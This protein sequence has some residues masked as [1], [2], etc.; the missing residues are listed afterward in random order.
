MKKSIYV[1]AVIVIAVLCFVSCGKKSTDWK[2]TYAGNIPCADCSGIDVEIALADSTYVVNYSYFGKDNEQKEQWS[3]T[4]AWDDSSKVITLDSKTLPPY[5]KVEENKLIQ[6][7][8]EGNTINGEHADMYV[9][10]K[11]I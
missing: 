7:D 9:L 1:T 8:M 4:F 11:K 3:G 6:L 5:Y 10:K 2:G